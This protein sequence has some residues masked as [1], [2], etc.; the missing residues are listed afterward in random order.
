M[1]SNRVTD[2]TDRFAGFIIDVMAMTLCVI[3]GC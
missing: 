1:F 3:F 2:F